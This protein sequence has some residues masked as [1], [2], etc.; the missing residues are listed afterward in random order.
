MWVRGLKQILKNITNKLCIVAP[1]V[2]AWI[3]T[4]ESTPPAEPTPVA[5]HVGAWIETNLLVSAK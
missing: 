2:G 1:H 5:P 4:A 3:E